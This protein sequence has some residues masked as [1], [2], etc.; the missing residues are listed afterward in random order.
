MLINRKAVKEIETY[1]N[2][3]VV[4]HLSIATPEKAIVSRLKVSPFLSWVEKG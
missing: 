4:A 1:F 2:R 3:K